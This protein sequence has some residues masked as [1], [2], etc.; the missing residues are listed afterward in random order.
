MYAEY[1]VK[2]YPIAKKKALLIIDITERKKSTKT[3]RLMS[4]GLDL[5]STGQCCLFHG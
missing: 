2:T 3:F 5:I 4:D 1:I